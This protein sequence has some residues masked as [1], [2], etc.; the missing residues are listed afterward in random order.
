[1][2]SAASPMRR[3]LKQILNSLFNHINSVAALPPR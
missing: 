1:M 2:G 3:G